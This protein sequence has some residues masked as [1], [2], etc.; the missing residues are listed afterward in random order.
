MSLPSALSTL[1]LWL[2]NR[3]QKSGIVAAQA[4]QSYGGSMGSPQHAEYFQ[5]WNKAIANSP[6]FKSRPV[7]VGLA[8]E[9]RAQL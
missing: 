4:A 7:A 8:V 1:T 3:S 6:K 9:T 5:A 2:H